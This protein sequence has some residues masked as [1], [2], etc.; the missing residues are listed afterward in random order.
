MPLA[1]ISLILSRHFSLLFI[2][3]ACLQGFIPY[4]HIATV[5][6][7]ELVVLFLLDHMRG[8]IGIQYIYVYIDIDI[9]VCTTDQL[10]QSLNCF[11]RFIINANFSADCKV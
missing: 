7:F 6:M 4:P 2:A 9:Y 8:S 1:R 11:S 3:L 10:G 5:G